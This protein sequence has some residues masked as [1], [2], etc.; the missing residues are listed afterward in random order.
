MK[1]QAK[2]LQKRVNLLEEQLKRAV[3]DYHNLESRVEK[4][5]GNF[6]RNS[7]LSLVDKLL[8]VLDDLQRAEKSIKNKGLSMAMNQFEEVLLSEGVGEIESD[9]VDFD[10]Q[11]M[12]CVEM[13][14]GKKNIIV[15]TLSKGYTLNGQVVRP[16][17]V[18]VGQGGKK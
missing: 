10:P 1:N 11:T 3:A 5:I 17:K 15:K 13:G 18:R 12:D 14:K 9:G 7:L 6:K 2:S 4:E 16:A 8:G